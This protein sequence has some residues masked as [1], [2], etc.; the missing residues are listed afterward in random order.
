MNSNLF[1]E[2]EK[3]FT[4][5][6]YKNTTV[7]A[8]INLKYCCDE[9]DEQNIIIMANYFKQLPKFSGLSDRDIFI[10]L[11]YMYYRIYNDQTENI[12]TIEFVKKNLENERLAFELGNILFTFSEV[13]KLFTDEIY[14]NKEKHTNDF[15]NKIEVTYCCSE[16]DKLNIFIM[17]NFIKQL[18]DFSG[19]SDRDIFIIVIFIFYSLRYSEQNEDLLN[20]NFLESNLETK[21][22]GIRLFNEITT[23]DITLNG[24]N[25][26]STIRRYIMGFPENPHGGQKRKSRK[27]RKSNFFNYLL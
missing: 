26:S 6:I 15:N 25:V 13:E 2:V 24:I 23:G 21:N 18:S 8:Q 16:H 10:I 4:D 3:L 19:L 11:I 7:N 9:D 12:F 17:S 1:L 20:V 14:K 27:S 5:E 22:L